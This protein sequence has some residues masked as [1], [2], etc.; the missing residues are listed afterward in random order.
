MNFQDLQVDP[1]KG[2][3]VLN[4]IGIHPATVHDPAKEHRL[5]EVVSFFQD[6]PDKGFLIPKLLKGKPGIDPID[7]LWGYVN[8]RTSY[9][10]KLEEVESLKKQISFYE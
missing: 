1:I 9:A 2:T 3:E 7:H 5:R 10:G 6:A 8:L 4:L